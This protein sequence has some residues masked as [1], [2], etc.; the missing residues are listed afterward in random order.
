MTT[1]RPFGIDI[2]LFLLLINSWPLS[3]Q[4]KISDT[5][6]GP[7]TKSPKPPDSS[8]N[9]QTIHTSESDTKESWREFTNYF[10]LD[11]FTSMNAS[12]YIN[13]RGQSTDKHNY[14]LYYNLNV[15]NQ[16][17]TKYLSVNAFL[18]N[19]LGYRQYIDSIRIKNEDSY[20]YKF[21]I[22]TPLRQQLNFNLSYLVKSQLWNSW[23]Y[24]T[25]STNQSKA[26]LMSSYFS[27]GYI[28]YSGGFSYNFW[29]IA[30]VE[31][32]LVGGEIT[33]IKNNNLYNTRKEDV[34]F[35]IEKGKRKQ[36]NFG[37][38]AQLQIPIHSINK[39]F[40][41]ENNSR[42]FVK[43]KDIQ[44]LKQYQID[45]SNGIHFLF[46]KYLRIGLR[47]K[48]TYDINVSEKIYISNMILFGF[49]LSNKM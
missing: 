4:P 17:N 24:R 13:P 1:H 22:N 36:F 10:R 49:Y 46:L 11:F 14:Y 45:V 32:G 31:L 35:G 20:S 34:V 25:D 5:I 42:L 37:L 19:E 7:T 43:G 30:K 8:V 40:Y 29:K 41:W 38:S 6:I 23:E 47:T 39:F 44:Q 26:I 9:K 28:I 15:T 18:F 3:A 16:F 21:D 48:L 12:H 33:K 2:L 27:P